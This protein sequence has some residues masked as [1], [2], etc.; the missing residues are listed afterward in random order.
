[1]LFGPWV[2]KRGSCNRTKREQIE[3]WVGCAL[4]GKLGNPFPLSKS[5]LPGLLNGHCQT[6]TFLGEVLEELLSELQ[7]QCNEGD[8]FL[9]IVAHRDNL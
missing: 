4:A 3:L 5:Q 7:T 9:G 2:E 1:M 6:R 8:R